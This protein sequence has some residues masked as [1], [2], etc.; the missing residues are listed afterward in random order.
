MSHH[1]MDSRADGAI[2]ADCALAA[3]TRLVP[4]RFKQIKLVRFMAIIGSA[5]IS[6][7]SN[8]MEPLSGFGR[9]ARNKQRFGRRLK[10]SSGVLPRGI[11]ICQEAKIVRALGP[12]EANP[13]P[14][15][16]GR[17]AAVQASADMTG[18]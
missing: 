3:D 17:P 10:V 11:T 7:L 9:K 2:S 1:S 4:S 16:G 6:I 18:L 12:I 5:I 15:P 14:F 8:M 13:E